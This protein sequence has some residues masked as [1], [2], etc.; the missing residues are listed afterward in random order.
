MVKGLVLAGGTGS[1]LAPLTQVTN[2]HLLPVGRLPMILHPITKLVRAGIKDIMIIT[3]TEHAGAVFQLLGSGA[4]YG[5][6]LTYRVQDQSGGI[7]QA[8]ALARAFVGKDPFCCILGDNIFSAELRQYVIGFTDFLKSVKTWQPA[9][10]VLLKEVSDPERYGVA[11]IEKGPENGTL[12][13][14]VEKPSAPSPSPWAVTGIYF[15]QGEGLF[16]IIDGLRPSARGELEITDLNNEL[17]RSGVLTARNLDGAWT[18]A[19]TFESLARVQ[20][21]V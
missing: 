7:A 3:G 8:L 14:F 4:G 9:G 20:G 15:Y 12:R 16:D 19:G 2:K 5:C 17:L 10:M 18:D 6:S 13:G 11:I 21:I 1:R